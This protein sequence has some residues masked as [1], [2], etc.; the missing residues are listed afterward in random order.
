MSGTAPQLFDEMLLLDGEAFVRSCYQRLLQ[1]EPDPAGLD[2]HL[3]A[4]ANG[5]SKINIALGFANSDEAW[6][7][8][9]RQSNLAR[10]IRLRSGL[11]RRK[12]PIWMG[13]VKFVADQIIQAETKKLSNSPSASEAATEIAPAPSQVTPMVAVEWVDSEVWY[14]TIAQ[15]SFSRKGRPQIWMDLTTAFQWTGG[16]VG[17]VRAELE[18]AC[19]IKKIDSSVRFSMQVANGFVEILDQEIQWLLDAENVVEAY[20][21]FFARYKDR[22]AEPRCIEV[23]APKV[24]DLF[25]PFSASD[26]VLAVGWMDSQKENYFTRLKSALPNVYIVYLVYDIILLL[27][28]TKHFY[29]VIGRERFQRYLKWISHHCDLVLFGGATAQRDTE[30]L[31]RE[32]GWPTPPGQ[33]VKFGTDIVK[34]SEYSDENAV[35]NK[36]GINGP[37]IMTVG[38]IEPRK[39]HE[40][41]YRA[42][43]MALELESER[44]PQMIFVGKPMWRAD[45]MI[46]TIQRHPKLKGRLLCLT[47]TDAELAVLYKHCRFTLLPSLYEGWSLTLPESLGQGKFCL[48]AD[49]PPLREIGQDLVDYVEPLD[50]HAWAEKIVAY[51]IDDQRLLAA[52]QR[53]V[54]EW[55]ETRWID[56]ARMAYD[57]IASHVS[58][59]QPAHVRLDGE[60]GLGGLRSP[61][62]WMD[63]TLSFLYGGGK[64]S[65]IVRAELE[66]AKHLKAIDPNTRYFAYQQ[67]GDYFFEVKESGLSW[68]FDN[69]DLY[70]AYESFE[71]FWHYHEQNGTGHRDPFFQNGQPIDWHEA[72]LPLFPSNSIIFFAGIDSDGT[73]ELYR[74]KKVD[75]LVGPGRAIIRSQ[76]IY[77]LT[78]FLYPQFHTPQTCKGFVPFFQHVSNSFEHLVYGGNTARR[79][80][81]AVQKENG[82]LAPAGDFIEFGSNISPA[83]VLVNPVRDR[84]VLEKFELQHDFILAVG[85][86]EPRKNH[87]VLYKAYLLLLKKNLLDRPLQLV[88][89]GK[90]GWKSEDFM[91]NLLADERVRSKIII[92]S[93]DDEEL[94]VL[95]R[96]CLFTA[97]PS[98][99]E[100]WSLTLPESLTYGKFCIASDVAPLRETGRD[101]VDYV[102]PL[103]PMAWAEHIARYA[104]SPELLSEREARI[105]RG[106]KARDW[107]SSA[108]ML[109]KVLKA[110]H[111]KSW[112]SSKAIRSK[113]PE[114][115]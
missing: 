6:V 60:D 85:T 90:K 89:V 81:M 66:F 49:T 35:L 24:D 97:L 106:W 34:L 73:G 7:K 78:P 36:L 99:Y 28:E 50:V 52:E 9:M 18:I 113:S 103:D 32:M 105:K 25:H 104:N 4:L 37:F 22:Q 75:A 112:E 95:Y 54:A 43:L 39:N 20:M 23:Q 11:K 44:T 114:G 71:Q 45:N 98:F 8:G 93:P 63:L 80:G 67:N 74:T 27:D 51:S 48:C 72:Y 42:Y 76:L 96:H 17:I 87:E 21:T 30:A 61:A 2:H 101:L 47:P 79:D 33:P 110:A 13:G 12:L 3:V 102:H 82:W 40:T 59:H 65:G 38:S 31:Q 10:Q 69:T 111:L 57:A 64:I 55:P 1:R 46:D 62:I 91:A 107:R 58:S 53:I 15:K 94:D 109:A 92:I 100:G 108:E 115:L 41:L 86:I 5:A 83:V 70:Q 26:I 19:G 84:E 56:T 16:V 29:D 77:D 68:L 14:S 88:I